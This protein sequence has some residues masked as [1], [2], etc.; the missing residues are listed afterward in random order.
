[1]GSDHSAFSAFAV[2]PGH[3]RSLLKLASC[4]KQTIF[5]TAGNWRQLTLHCMALLFLCLQTP[6]F[7]TAAHTSSRSTTTTAA[8]AASSNTVESS[9]GLSP[10]YEALQ[11]RCG[12]GSGTSSTTPAAA[13]AVAYSGAFST[14]N[15]SITTAVPGES[16]WCRI[17]S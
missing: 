5:T 11:Q 17:V 14:T 7:V 10:Q 9:T 2:S 4:Q 1:M 16:C 8:A 13:A 15:D 12:L 6:D 3:Q